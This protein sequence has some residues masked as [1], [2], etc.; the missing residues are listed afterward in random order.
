ML[1]LPPT[2]ATLFRAPAPS[3]PTVA[4]RALLLLVPALSPPWAHKDSA[5]SAACPAL[6][7]SKWPKSYRRVPDFHVLFRMKCCDARVFFHSTTCFFLCIIF[8]IPT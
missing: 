7:L 3:C 2:L 4:A 1:P 8:F 5:T 6:S